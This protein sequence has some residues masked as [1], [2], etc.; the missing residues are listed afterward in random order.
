M[1]DLRDAAQ[2]PAPDLLALYRLRWGIEEV[3]Q[4][5][6]EVFHLQALIGTT[7]QGTV[8]QFAFCLL[9][10]NLLQVVRGYIATAQGRPLPQTLRSQAA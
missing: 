1:V 5:V 7:P 2:Y 10:Y 9:F 3:F 8:F 6:T 4:P